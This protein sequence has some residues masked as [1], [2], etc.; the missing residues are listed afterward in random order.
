MLITEGSVRLVHCCSTECVSAR[1]RAPS[2]TPT[3][4]LPGSVAQHELDFLLGPTLTARYIKLRE[5]QRA[6]SNP[7]VCFCPRQGC[8]AAVEPEPGVSPDDTNMR[9][10]GQCGMPFC[11]VCGTTWHGVNPCPLP[12]ATSIV[13]RYLAADEAEQQS[14][15]RRYGRKNIQLL[16]RTFEEERAN[17]A[18]KDANTTICK[19]CGVHIEKSAGCSELPP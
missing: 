7:A 3:D 12:K 6:E 11:C 18:W 5:K 10:C 2:S 1:A 16:V 15:E 14:L 13:E 17:A 19:H 9:Q 4:E 8:G